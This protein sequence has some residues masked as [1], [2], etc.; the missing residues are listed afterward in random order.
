MKRTASAE[1]A[2]RAASLGIESQSVR[3]T[4]VPHG[5][6]RILA[7][8]CNRRFSIS[9]TGFWKSSFLRGRS[10]SSWATQSRS[11]SLWMHRSVPFGDHARSP[12]VYS[13]MPR[14]QGECGSQK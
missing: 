6:W 11:A 8:I 13:L 12:L 10:L 1:Q 3:I 4:S 5:D 9:S 14:Y 7:V 2:Y